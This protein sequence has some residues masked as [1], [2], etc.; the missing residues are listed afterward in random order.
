MSPPTAD[1]LECVGAAHVVKHDSCWHRD[2]IDQ[3]N[4]QSTHHRCTEAERIATVYRLWFVSCLGGVA[5]ETTSD[6]PAIPT[7]IIFSVE[8]KTFKTREA[9]LLYRTDGSLEE[10]VVT[11]EYI[12]YFTVRG[13]SYL[14]RLPK[15]WPPIP[16]YARRV[17]PPPA[18]KAGGTHSPGG[19]GEGG[20]IFWKTREI[21]WPSYSNGLSTVVTMALAEILS[22]KYCSCRFKAF[23]HCMMW[24]KSPMASN[25][26][27]LC[28]W[29]QPNVIVR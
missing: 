5:K 19:E 28:D 22:C 9:Q 20:S 24:W 10:F 11:T 3:S 26:R 6:G 18:T 2:M 4:Y 14:S 25:A 13:Q 7:L 15:Y 17:C 23:V 21:G 12:Q 8:K 27:T 29:E 1:W 16:L